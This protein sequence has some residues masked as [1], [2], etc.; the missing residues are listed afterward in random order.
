MKYLLRNRPFLGFLF[1][2]I[3][4]TLVGCKS[5]PDRLPGDAKSQ[6]DGTFPIQVVATIGMVADVIRNVGGQHVQVDQICGP[7]V[8]PHL[9]HVSTDDVR[10]L[11]SADMVFYS[12]L[13]LEGKMT[14]SLITVARKK[15]VF[16]VTEIIDKSLL[17]E[18][19]EFAGH[20][21]PHVW[22]DVSAWESTASAVQ[23]ALSEFDP[24]HATDYQQ[25]ASQYKA[26]LNRLHQYGIE[27]MATVPEES[28]VLVTSHDAF[29]YFGRAYGLQV[30]GV[31]GL[32]TESEAGVQ[33]IND[34]VDMLVKKNVKAIFIESS[35]SSKNIG[36]LQEG[37]RSKGHSVVIADKP[38]FS[39]AMGAT[40]TYEGTYEGMLDHNITVVAHALGG[41]VDAKGL[42]GKLSESKK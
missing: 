19:Q 12:G 37:A 24:S 39:D 15:P 18:P 9:Y 25:N 17:L 16:A 38:L 42:N 8:D 6:F 10:R 30:Y 13:M 35:V 14:D 22:N 34:L 31:Q 41:K 29:N 5:E 7:G 23:A 40:G 27:A 21:D 33:H 2:L 20:Y 11:N 3:A 1:A 32:S 26:K 28:R 4:V 36:A